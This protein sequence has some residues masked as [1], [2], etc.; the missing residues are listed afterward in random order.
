MGR[1]RIPPESRKIASQRK[2][3]LALVR[4]RD[5]AI[6]LALALVVLL[7]FGE[8]AKFFVPVRFQRSGD[9]TI[10]RVP[11]PRAHRGHG[12]ANAGPSQD[13]ES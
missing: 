6:V 5:L 2:D 11:G 3:L 12:P 10:I 4:I 9:E 13:S 7:G 1:I 8:R